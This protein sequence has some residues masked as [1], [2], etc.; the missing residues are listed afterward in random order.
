MQLVA[1]SA[2]ASLVSEA[3]FPVNMIGCQLLF[4]QLV[5]SLGVS[6][7]LQLLKILLYPVRQHVFFSSC[8]VFAGYSGSSS[9]T[10][11]HELLSKISRQF[12]FVFFLRKIHTL[13]SKSRV[14][15]IYGRELH[16]EAVGGARSAALTELSV[17]WTRGMIHTRAHTHINSDER[18]FMRN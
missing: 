18:H 1:A 15:C 12:C 16:S 6:A 14:T 3:H 13:L 5:H 10:N 8:A 9:S 2:A 11:S 17:N 7:L 4:L